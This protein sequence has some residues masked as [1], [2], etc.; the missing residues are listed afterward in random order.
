MTRNSPVADKIHA[1]RDEINY[2]NHRYY[3]LDDPQIP[4]KEYDRLFR[5]L[6]SLEQQHPELITSD[7]PTQRVGATPLEMFE[8]VKHLVPMLSL[9]NAFDAQEVEDFERRIRERAEVDKVSY[10]AEPKLDGLAVSLLYENGVLVRAATRGDGYSGE[11]VTQNI[12]TIESIP[13]RLL[14]DNVPAVLEVRG[15]VIMTKSGFEKLNET[16]RRENQKTFANP[17]N[18]AAGS[19]RQLDSKITA[20]RPLDFYCYAMGQVEGLSMPDTHLET[21]AQLREWGLRVNSEATKVEGVAGCLAYYDTIQKK[22]DSLD[23]DIDGVVYKVD[24]LAVQ[25]RVGFVSRAPR[26]AVAHK[27]AAQEEMTT[28]LAIDIQVGRT[29]ALTPVAR[30]ERRV[31]KEC[32]AGICRRCDGHQC[33]I[34]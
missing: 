12:R 28:L 11:D 6:Q 29:G 17:R 27:F 2:H 8:E 9:N 32:R 20:S 3:V 30:L 19:L 22:R 21:L 33:H 10:A 14:G 15:E 24:D 23:Y 31:G 13:L 16:Q 5:E 7:S 34:T 26:W 4:D 25:T 18:A 1:L